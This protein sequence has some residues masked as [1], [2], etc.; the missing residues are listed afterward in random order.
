LLAASTTLAQA[1]RHMPTEAPSQ[2]P[3]E[4]PSPEEPPSPPRATVFRIAA[5]G[6]YRPLFDLTVLGGGIELSLGRE[7]ERH[8]GYVNLH[9]VLGRTAAG[10]PVL[11]IGLTGTYEVHFGGLRFG[12]GGGMNLLNLDRAS[13]GSDVNSAG[14]TTLF[15]VGYDFGE[16][17]GAFVLGQYALDLYSGDP[18]DGS[19]T[20]LGEA[21][22][23]AGARF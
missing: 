20:F 8:G 10:L 21:K 12:V 9:G 16:R 22:L 19:L 4:A 11:E 2:V 23:I 13:N 6:A 14:L 18:V 7:G 1:P 15:R 17:P 3:T 5:E